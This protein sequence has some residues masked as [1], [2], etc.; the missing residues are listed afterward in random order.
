M[1]PVRWGAKSCIFCCRTLPPS[2]IDN[3]ALARIRPSARF[4]LRV[5][6][7]LISTLLSAAG[8][9]LTL[10]PPSLIPLLG[11]RPAAGPSFDGRALA[12][13]Q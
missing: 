7:V 1:R 3:S 2:F 9:V 6:Q 8:L 13:N 11:G 12:W 4:R 10:L 5:R